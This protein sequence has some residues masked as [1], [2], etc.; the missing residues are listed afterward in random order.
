[1]S[2][3]SYDTCMRKRKVIASLRVIL[4]SFSIIKPC[5]KPGLNP[6]LFAILCCWF[7]FLVEW[8]AAE[9]PAVNTVILQQTYINSPVYV[10]S[11]SMEYKLVGTENRFTCRNQ[12]WVPY[13][14]RCHKDDSYA[15]TNTQTGECHYTLYWVFSG[16]LA[17]VIL[18]F[19]VFKG[20]G[21][22]W[23]TFS[24]APNSIL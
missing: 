2:K 9:R 1:M 3:F 5:L 20:E 6:N 8:C 22:F 19:G 7:M 11:C 23:S 13:I 24:C 4:L 21:N 18:G 14:P 10:A 17:C 16:Q 12:I 15:N